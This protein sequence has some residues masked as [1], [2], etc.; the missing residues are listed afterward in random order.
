MKQLLWIPLLLVAFAATQIAQAAPERNVILVHGLNSGPSTFTQ[1][2]ADLEAAG[3]KVWSPQLPRTGSRSGDSVTNAKF[4]QSYIKANG[5][6]NVVLV[7]HSLGG[8]V[9]EYYTRILNQGEIVGRVTLD[10]NIQSKA[11]DSGWTCWFVPDQCNG[12]VRNAIFAANPR[13]DIPMLNMTSSGITLGP[14]L[15]DCNY[16]FSAA[17]TSYPSQSFVRQTVVGWT[18][19]LANC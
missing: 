11:G 16:K 13:T 2:K 5:L 1:M 8:T 14:P 12:P 15:V 9:V 3:Y 18:G 19:T 17:H 10:S 4:I 6:S 7:G